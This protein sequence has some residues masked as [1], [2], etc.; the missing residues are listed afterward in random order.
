MNLD[1][2]SFT[3][4]A[5]GAFCVGFSKTGISGLGIIPVS[6]FAMVF[7]P[8]QSSGY[9]LPLLILGDIFS[10]ALYRRHAQ[11]PHLLRIFPWAAGGIV[12]AY[13]MLRYLNDQAAGQDAQLHDNDVLA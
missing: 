13:F 8:L 11:W 9:L 7:P 5:L 12:A 1:W 3:L 10:V 4:V 2:I 6:L